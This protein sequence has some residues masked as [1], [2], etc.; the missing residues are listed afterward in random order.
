[1]S[2]RRAGRPLAAAATILNDAGAHAKEDV[3]QDLLDEL[4]G[5]RAKND[6]EKNAIAVAKI[7]GPILSTAISRAVEP[8]S[9]GT[10]KMQS[11]IRKNTYDLDKLQQ[12][13]RRENLRLHGIA[14]EEGENLKDIIAK[15][16]QALD[17][18]I[19]STDINVVHRSGPK[20]AR[21]RQVICRFLSRD[22]KVALLKNKKK[23]KENESFKGVYMYEDLTPLRARLLRV[24]KDL[25]N[26]KSAFTRE[27]V[28][29]C[30][31]QNGSHMIVE[32]PDDLFRLGLD[33][34]NLEE[35]GLQFVDF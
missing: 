30:Y 22:Y 12:Y 7:L 29:H 31:L 14:E 19:K 1:M 21:P 35:L 23:L 17:V 15:I 2:Q 3:V 26:V 24:A 6:H 25:P 13:G 18:E 9:K 10:Q 32:S 16:G 4:E 28:I 20:G 33:D 34:I 11:A 5:K 27:G 8:V